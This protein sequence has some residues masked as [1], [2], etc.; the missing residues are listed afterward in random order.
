MFQG[1]GDNQ[2]ANK[3]QIKLRCLRH[4]QGGGISTPPQSPD[5]V[6]GRGKICTQN[7]DERNQ[8]L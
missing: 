1:M 3:R 8:K 2:E 6:L 4:R 7:I 5:L